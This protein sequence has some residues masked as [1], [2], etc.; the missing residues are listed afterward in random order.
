MN[1]LVGAV[2]A[3]VL[4]MP[5]LAAKAPSKDKQGT[6]AEQ[7]QALT[8]EFQDTYQNLVKAF[9]AAKTN[10]DR[11]KINDDYVKLDGYAPKMLELAEK[12]PKDPAA[13]DALIWAATRG[14]KAEKDAPK[15]KALAILQRDHVKSEKIGPIFG[16]LAHNLTAE[17]EKFAREVM[18]KNPDRKIQAQAS[19]ALVEG[20]KNKGRAT[21][22]EKLLE[23]VAKKYSDLGLPLKGL[24]SP[25]IT[26]VDQDGKKFKLSDYAGKVVLLDFWGNW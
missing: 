25:D 13:V 8:K 21:E 19:L 6:P 4:A 23:M 26:G 7:Y 3:L 20:L 9:R 15:T 1:R 14:I 10:E 24:K 11:Q 2:L 16:A 5:A 12:H 18:D 17:T 22:S